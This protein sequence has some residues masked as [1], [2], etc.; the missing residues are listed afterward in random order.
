MFAGVTASSMP[1]VKQFFAR[2][3]LLPKFRSS[4]LEPKLRSINIFSKHSTSTKPPRIDVTFS[5]W[6]KR[7]TNHDE[8]H[9]MS[10]DTQMSIK[11]HGLSQSNESNN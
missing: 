2:H 10:S 5:K 11:T 4:Y 7:S 1:T 3:N 9:E 8:E 6:R